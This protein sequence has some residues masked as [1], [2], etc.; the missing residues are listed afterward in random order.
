VSLWYDLTRKTALN[1]SV[2]HVMTG[3]R[4]TVLSDGRLEK[5]KVRGD[6]T[7]VHAGIAYRLC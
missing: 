3:L 1:L 2:G 6:T 4:L 5:R 7:I